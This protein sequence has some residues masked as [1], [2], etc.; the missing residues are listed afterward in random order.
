M[1]ARLRRLPA[2]PPA[3]RPADDVGGTVPEARLR[4]ACGAT[5]GGAAAA[6]GAGGPP[7]PPPHGRRDPHVRGAGPALP[8]DEDTVGMLRVIESSVSF[9]ELLMNNTLDMHKVQEQALELQ[10]EPCDLS[11]LL[12][13]LVALLS[14]A[15]EQRQGVPVLADF[16]L[17]MPAVVCDRSRVAR[18]LM[19]LGGNS[20]KFTHDGAITVRAR[21][22][23]AARRDGDPALLPRLRGQYHAAVTVLWGGQPGAAAA[24]Q[25]DPHPDCVLPADAAPGSSAGAQRAHGS[26]ELLR[27]AAGS[28]CLGVDPLELRKHSALVVPAAGA[29][30]LLADTSDEAAC[31]RVA[32]LPCASDKALPPRRDLVVEFVV[33]D[34]GRGMPLQALQAC[35]E[36]Y[37]RSSAAE[38]G[39]SGMGLYI[40]RSFVE[41][42][43][44]SMVVASEEGKGTATWIRIRVQSVEG[45]AAPPA[46]AIQAARS[47]SDTLE[48]RESPVPTRP[49]EPAAAP[50][51][52]A[53]A[54]PHRRVLVVDDSRIN[55]RLLCKLI[56]RML[57]EFEVDSAFDG[58]QALQLMQRRPYDVVW[59]DID[60]P[61]MSGLEAARRYCVWAAE[62]ARD[63]TRSGG[64]ARGGRSDSPGAFDEGARTPP[65]AFVPAYLCALTGNATHADVERAY[66]AGFN[67]FIVKPCRP[68]DI[69]HALLQ[70]GVAEITI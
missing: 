12:Q 36:L 68:Q 27:L 43:R 23:D 40:V 54:L 67:L 53:R 4:F 34:T 3:A 70:A 18:M 24:A 1:L 37:Q 49:S 41:A 14:T 46:Q 52:R 5:A 2:V 66:E 21:V 35:T 25:R 17:D 13:E 26:A 60:M 65:G 39:G 55:V 64:V 8:L 58:L 69:A 47:R 29:S 32:P 51:A 30:S 16:P 45:Q 10:E 42:Y 38:G 33:E 59:L 50:A 7:S 28:D 57:P 44:G 63:R 15:S 62:L 22:V 9:L 20:L 56:H 19:N 6:Y 31:V 11:A 61:V 48:A